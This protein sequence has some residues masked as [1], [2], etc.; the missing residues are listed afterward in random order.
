MKT[1][2]DFDLVEGVFSIYHIAAM[3]WRNVLLCS[4]AHMV[5]LYD[6]IMLVL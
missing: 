3:P 4:V 1:K 2:H 6:S 5:L